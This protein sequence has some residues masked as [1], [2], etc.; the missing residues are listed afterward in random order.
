[1]AT[2][3]IMNSGK[4]LQTDQDARTQDKFFGYINVDPI[5]FEFENN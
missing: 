1:L 4:S 2:P 3:Q 5:Y